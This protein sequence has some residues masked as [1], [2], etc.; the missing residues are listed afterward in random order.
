[1]SIVVAAGEGDPKYVRYAGFDEAWD[2]VQDEHSA[3]E[4]EGAVNVES[5]SST[6]AIERGMASL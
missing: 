2:G 3:A 6:G 4:E 5:A 1:L